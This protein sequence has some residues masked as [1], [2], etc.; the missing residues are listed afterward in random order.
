MSKLFS[1]LLS[2]LVIVVLYQ[3]PK[4][5]NL[6]SI[7]SPKG[8]ACVRKNTTII[9]YF[10]NYLK[11]NTFFL[12][13][14]F[15]ILYLLDKFFLMSYNQFSSSFRL[16]EMFVVEHAEFFLDLKHYYTA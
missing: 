7:F 16:R 14:K 11:M 13:F 6:F 9:G 3:D 8:N 1:V 2:T 4:H 5:Q 12:N 10:I 15:Q